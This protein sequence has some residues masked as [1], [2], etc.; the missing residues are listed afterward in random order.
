M[1]GMLYWMVLEVVICKE[2]GCK[3]DIWLFGIM[4]IEMIEGELLYLIEFL[5]CVLWF[6]V[7]NGMFQIKN[8]DELL[9]V[10]KDFLYFVLKV[11][12]EK[13]VSV[14]DLLRVSVFEYMVYDVVKVNMIYSMS[15]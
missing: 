5:L 8:E 14:Y 3:V 9:L 1:V 4:V 13:R 15:L 10:F 12:L 11:D 6:I 7:M 2:Y